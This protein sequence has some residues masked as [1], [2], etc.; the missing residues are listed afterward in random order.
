MRNILFFAG[1]AVL[2]YGCGPHT[3]K[4]NDKQR[5]IRQQVGVPLSYALADQDCQNSQKEVAISSQSIFEWNGKTTSRTKH[6]FVDTKT[7]ESIQTNH[8]SQSV[9]NLHQLTTENCSII[10]GDTVCKK[11]G[12][13]QNV[14]TADNIRI[15]DAE[16]K[17]PRESIEAVT[18][19]SLAHLQ[20]AN[21]FYLTIPSAKPSIRDAALIVLPKIET[22][23]VK[24]NDDGSNIQLKTM[25]TDNAAFGELSQGQHVF[26][27]FPKSEEFKQDEKWQDINLWEIPYVMSHEYAHQIFLT[28]YENYSA[29]ASAMANFKLGNSILK[30]RNS[31]PWNNAPAGLQLT[32]GDS[33]R[34]LALGAI[35]EGFADL[36]GF[37]ATGDSTTTTKDLPCFE[38]SRDIHTS[39]FFDGTPK[40]LLELYAKSFLG[41][42]SVS[43]SEEYDCEKFDVSDSHQIGAIFA[44]A[45]NQIFESHLGDQSSPE[46]KTELALTWLNNLNK[47]RNIQSAPSGDRIFE[48]TLLALA[49]TVK[50]S[51]KTLSQTHCDILNATFPSYGHVVT[52]SER[53]SCAA[54]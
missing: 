29:D 1:L 32:S 45:M 27:V 22:N 44:Y 25:I 42:L 34:S 5:V 43:S 2:S 35:N 31:P 10:N 48:I 53:W 14:T 6:D 52:E 21:Q 51:D 26:I 38:R 30:Q 13:T 11:V 3:V 36:I 47:K 33:G 37:Y 16:R 20:Q 46:T 7:K 23:Y 12:K 9:Y 8:I 54:E 18:L 19:T 41:G 28:H 40:V 24:R 17:F 39:E 15:C 4:K 50:I 49:E